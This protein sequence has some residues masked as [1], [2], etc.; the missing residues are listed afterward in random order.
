MRIKFKKS[1]Y[2]IM[3]IFTMASVPVMASEIKNNGTEVIY[4]ED[5]NSALFVNGELEVINSRTDFLQQSDSIQISYQGNRITAKIIKK[6]LETI[7]IVA[8]LYPSQSEMYKNNALVGVINSIS[9]PY[10]LVSFRIENNSTSFSLMKPNLDLEGHIVLNI[11]IQDINTGNIYYWQE[12]VDELNFPELL[13]N[14]KE[15]VSL[16]NISEEE[17]NTLELDYLQLLT[18]NNKQRESVS[19]SFSDSSTLDISEGDLSSET[20]KIETYANS[21]IPNVPDSVFKSGAFDTWKHVNKKDPM[22]AYSYITSRYAGTDNRLTYIVAIEIPVNINWNSKKI[23]QQL[24]IATNRTVVYNVYNGTLAF[25]NNDQRIKVQNPEI[26]FTSNTVNGVFISRYY[27][28]R[29]QG[30]ILPNILKAIL[31]ICPYSSSAIYGFEEL[32][33]S[34]D[35]QTGNKYTHYANAKEQQKIYGHI[36]P[37][38]TSSVSL[39]QKQNDYFLFES[40]FDGISNISYTYNYSVSY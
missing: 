33:A 3:G 6:D 26:K 11:G 38:M 5:S 20:E 25:F 27:S 9:N 15:K 35:L 22:F 8:D 32:T 39:L 1:L 30:T 37:Q 16:S 19:S 17:L 2:V 14:A 18:S 23:S 7:N 10:Q 31:A 12:A 29:K 40:E 24:T 28:C 21:L 34:T 4:I 13:N 36:I